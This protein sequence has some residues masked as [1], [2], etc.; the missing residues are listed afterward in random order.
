MVTPILGPM[1]SKGIC[2]PVRDEFVITILESSLWFGFP[3][4][5]RR[6]RK[7]GFDFSENFPTYNI[8]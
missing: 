5:H 8:V 2:C 1:W 4:I 6:V 3:E 7:V